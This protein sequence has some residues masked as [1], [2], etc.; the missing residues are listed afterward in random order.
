MNA[1]SRSGSARDLPTLAAAM[2]LSAFGDELALTALMIKVAESYGGTGSGSFSDGGPAVAAMLIA[3]VLPQAVL[4]PFAGL[5]VDRSESTRILRLASAAQALLACALAFVDGLGA[6]LV[7]VFLLGACASVAG[8]ATF[9]LIPSIASG[10]DTTRANG[11]LEASR[12]AGWVLGPIAA[13]TLADI[14]SAQTALLVDAASFVAIVVATIFLR[15]RS[16]PALDA[17]RE[18][19]LAEALAGFRAVGRDRVLIVAFVVI[20]LTV[21]F[22]AMDNVAEV[23]FAYDVLGRGGFSLGALATGWLA[24]MVVGAAVLAPRITPTRHAPAL[25]LAGVLGGIAVAVTALTDQLVPAVVLFAIAGIGNGV[26]NVS[27]RTLIHQR[28][29]EHMRG[30]VYAA[31]SGLTTAAQLSATALAGPLV[32]AA[33]AATALKIGGVGGAVVSAIGF[34]WLI[35]DAPRGK[36]GKAYGFEG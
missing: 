28:A 27:L 36:V 21:V 11:I 33:G 23:F 5:L 24:G 19:P 7:L 18:R 8:P 25:A 9:T 2:G 14:A 1:P 35:T 26:Q 34:V 3:G 13:G 31:S 15:A 16:A 4:A 29:P 20:G 22:A 6:I 17:T 10:E 12:Y 32:V 30:R